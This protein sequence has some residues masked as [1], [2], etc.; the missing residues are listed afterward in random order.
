MQRAVS[1]RSQFLVAKNSTAALPLWARRSFVSEA[2]IQ[3]ELEAARRV[4]A[5]EEKNA[6]DRATMLSTTPAPPQG[7]RSDEAPGQPARL[8]SAE[9][10]HQPA[11][12]SAQ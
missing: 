7:K 8:P 3:A 5:L 4:K 12:P 2:H 10:N 11:R 6:R 9:N 1:L